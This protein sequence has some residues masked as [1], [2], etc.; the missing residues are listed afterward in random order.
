[1]RAQA[2]DSRMPDLRSLPSHFR[3]EVADLIVNTY[4]VRLGNGSVAKRCRNNLGIAQRARCCRI[5]MIAPSAQSLGSRSDYA[6]TAK[7]RV[8]RALGVDTSVSGQMRRM[9]RDGNT[10]VASASP[11][12]VRSGLPRS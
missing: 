9:A 5:G 10:T 4:G 6:A 3:K 1:M 7:G 11:V 12:N 2:F 8:V